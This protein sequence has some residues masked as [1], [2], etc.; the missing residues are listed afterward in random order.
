[1]FFR[2]SIQDL[3]VLFMIDD[4]SWKL[5]LA[6]VLYATLMFLL[7]LEEYPIKC[8]RGPTM[9]GQQKNMIIIL[10]SYINLLIYFTLHV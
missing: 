6:G 8:S 7:E 9:V 1:M 10:R 3:I 5:G 2:L 4:G